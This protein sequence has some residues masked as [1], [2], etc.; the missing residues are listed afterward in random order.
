MLDD[1]ELALLEA[2]VAYDVAKAIVAD[3]R[4]A[5]VG[6]KV[7]RGRAK[8]GITQAVRGALLA[9]F[10]AG[11]APDIVALAK[12]K[13]A[14]GEPL[15][16]LLLG[17]NGAGKTTTMA[18]LASLFGE[19]GMTCVIAAADSF[20]AAAIEQAE[21]HGAKLGVHVV[22]HAYGADPAAVAFDAVNYA[23]AHRVNVV[24]MDTA[25]RQETNRNLVEEMKKMARVAKPDLTIFVGESIAGNA[26]VEQVKAFHA[27]VGL[28]GVIL[29]KLD[30]DAK[31]G[32]ALSVAR[33]AGVPILF[34]GVGQGYGDLE[35][36]DAE[37]LVA[38]LL[39]A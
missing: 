13:A 17:P 7:K 10:Q 6:M 14:A 26:L 37:R 4:S 38:A 15:R 18:K 24:L 23:R 35:R 3:L 8:E 34:F 5:L 36:F 31:G 28:D 9:Q 21:A 33:G 30:C 27:A 25:G 19:S 12:G 22:R 2:D 16:I 29:T 20:R 11:G 1:L 32:T 39:G